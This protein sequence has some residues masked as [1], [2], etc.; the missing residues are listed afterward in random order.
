MVLRVM[1]N[2]VIRYII[3]SVIV[4]QPLGVTIELKY[5]EPLLLLLL[6]LLLLS[7]K[8]LFKKLNLF[9]F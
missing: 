8:L 2:E 6:L 3:P 1:V 4:H 7:G 9:F 5:S